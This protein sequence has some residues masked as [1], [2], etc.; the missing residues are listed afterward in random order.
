MR[1]LFFLLRSEHS[2]E[3]TPGPPQ[4]GSG[5]KP[6]APAASP[7]P[8][9]RAARHDSPGDLPSEADDPEEEDRHGS[10]LPAPRPR[11]SGMALA[12]SAG[13]GPVRTQTGRAPRRSPA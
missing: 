3:E 13:S 5:R 8:Y 2:Q 4:A 9:R 12:L 10:R 1:D 6:G 7:Q 11:H